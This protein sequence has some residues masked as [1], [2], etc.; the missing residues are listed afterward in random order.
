MHMVEQVEVK[1][2]DKWWGILGWWRLACAGH[3][4]ARLS[5]LSNELR[6]GHL[7]WQMQHGRASGHVDSAA[8]QV[9]WLGFWLGGGL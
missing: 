9:G 5:D 8:V 3:V 4:G 1:W 6:C 7:A 2:V